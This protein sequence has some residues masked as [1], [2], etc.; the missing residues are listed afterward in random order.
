MSLSLKQ[1]IS[2]DIHDLI[3]APTDDQ[4]VQNIKP[5]ILVATAEFFEILENTPDPQ[6]AIEAYQH[7]LKAL[8]HLIYLAEAKAKAPA[9][10]PT[11]QWVQP[12]LPL[13]STPGGSQ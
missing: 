2:R 4:W 11:S 1:A 6:A 3:Q 10:E 7:R 13:W 12:E 8:T 9:P 5:G